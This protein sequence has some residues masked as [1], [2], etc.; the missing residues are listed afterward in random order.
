VSKY[1]EEVFEKLVPAGRGRLVMQRRID[2]VGRAMSGL[3]AGGLSIEHRELYRR[4]DSSI[5]QLEEG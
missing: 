4:L 2:E 5:I 1:F 3:T